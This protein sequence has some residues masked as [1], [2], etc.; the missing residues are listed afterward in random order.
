MRRYNEKEEKWRLRMQDWE[1]I[2]ACTFLMG[3]ALSYVV[4]D[5]NL[6]NAPIFWVAFFFWVASPLSL[7]YLLYIGGEG[8]LRGYHREDNEDNI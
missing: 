2:T 1:V 5:N 7:C 6:I 3:I 8:T 4:F